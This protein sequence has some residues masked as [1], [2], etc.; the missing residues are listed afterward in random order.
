MSCFKKSL[1]N[2]C[3]VS[4]IFF[5]FQV[6]KFQRYN[7]VMEFERKP[8]T[9]PPFIVI[10]HVYILI[11]FC[12]RKITNQNLIMDTSLKLFL[13]PDA[14]EKLHDFEEDCMEDY[15]K[16]KEMMSNASADEKLKVRIALQVSIGSNVFSRLF[17]REIEFRFTITSLRWSFKNVSVTG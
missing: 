9:P 6:W 8:V 5:L 1:G 15:F 16:E 11:K 2:S 3:N 12:Q 7:L 10:Y 13:D 14:V 4:H 17:F